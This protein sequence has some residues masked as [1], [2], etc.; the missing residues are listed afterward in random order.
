MA[1]I[2]IRI[3]AKRRVFASDNTQGQKLTFFG[4]D[5]MAYIAS[6]LIR[7]EA[8]RRVSALGNT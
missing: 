6:V 4:L 3:K 1:S 2:L 5:L 8:K 7:M